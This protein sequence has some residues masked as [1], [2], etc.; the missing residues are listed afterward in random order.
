MNLN[1]LFV[2]LVHI[3]ASLAE[4]NQTTL[5]QKWTAFKQS[6]KMRSFH[7][8]EEN[9]RRTIFQKRLQKIEEHNERYK[10]GLE[11]YEM[12]VNR[13]ATFTDKELLAYTGGL[14]LSSKNLTSESYI[15]ANFSQVAKISLPSSVDWRELGKV[16]PVKDQGACGSCWAFS[17]IGAIEAH[18]SISY[19]LNVSLSEQQL[20]DCARECDGCWGGYLDAAYDYIIN[21]G[22]VSYDSD[23]PY[24]A[25]DHCCQYVDEF[26]PKVAIQNYSYLWPYE[27][28]LQYYVATHGPVSVAIDVEDDFVYYSGG[29]YYNEWC[30]DYWLNHA[31][32]VVGYGTENGQDYWLVKNSWGSDWGLDGYIK[33]ARNRD[34][35]CG[36]ASSALVPVL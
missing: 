18:Y 17:V 14:K 19:D 2:L 35:N 20:L 30:S 16:T 31:V 12:V 36:I 6:Y 4:V 3:F 28:V 10:K 1:I 15:L 27:Q 11:T 32:V 25:I 29:V 33:M 8:K 23:Y 26:K 9:I 5:T 7:P 24:Q 21:S 34:N 22:G 13:F